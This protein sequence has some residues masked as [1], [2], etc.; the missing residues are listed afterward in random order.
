MS[1]TNLAQVQDQ[2]QKYWSPRF[3]KELRESLLLGGLVSK[4]YQGEI[5]Q[6]GDTVRVSQ[7]VAATGE[8]LDVGVNADSFNSE[9]LT[10]VKVDITAD[11]R[12][13]ASFK[14]ADLVEIQSQINKSDPE[15]MAALRFGMEKQINDYLYSLVAPSASSPDLIVNS[16]TTFD[17]STLQTLRQNAGQQKWPK[18]GN[19]W[20]LLDPVYYAQLMGVTSLTSSD[21]VG[22]QAVVEGDVAVR[23]FGFKIAE[24]NSRTSKYGIAFHPSFLNFVMQTEVQVKVSDRHVMGE[25]GYIMSVDL[26]FGAKLAYDGAYRHQ[27]VIAT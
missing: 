11:K 12:A 9:Q 1:T 22:D 23:R 16:V 17:A 7:I 24:D 2:I 8:L 3:T 21:Y 20:L 5:K 6:G 13:V 4:E 15:V 18:D 26:V 19:W 25:F 27:K 10:T 14:F